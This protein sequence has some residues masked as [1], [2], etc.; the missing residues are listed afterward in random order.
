MDPGEAIGVLEEIL[1]PP[2]SG[3]ELVSNQP[4]GRAQILILGTRHRVLLAVTPGAGLG[5]ALWS[6][7]RLRAPRERVKRVA[8]ASVSALAGI[9]RTPGSRLGVV[10]RLSVRSVEQGARPLNRVLADR[11]GLPSSRFMLV[12]RPVDRHY[13][14]TLTLLSSGGKP[15]A[16]AKYAW[17]AETAAMV[18]TEGQALAELQ[19]PHS[20]E[21]AIPELIGT[22]EFEGNP[23]VLTRPL[24]SKARRS[25]RE[26]PSEQVHRELLG[27]LRTAPAAEATNDLRAADASCRSS[28]LLEH[29]RDLLVQV[30]PRGVALGRSH[31]DWTPWNLA[32]SGSTTYAWDWEHYARWRPAGVDIVHWCLMRDMPKQPQE[33]VRTLEENRPELHRRLRG[34]TPD[35]DPESV[36]AFHLGQLLVRSTQLGADRGEDP[37]AVGLALERTLARLQ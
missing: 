2:G 36:I 26:L 19:L 32:V 10:G 27:P 9:A 18:R 25:G 16:F 11:H 29:A 5:R 21:L 17:R 33:W 13:K 31:G 12:L 1:A 23:Y 37:F 14:P 28:S 20:G 34:L 4:P 7:N 6:H 8:L 15:V 3:L 24:T 30:W 22:G 35:Q